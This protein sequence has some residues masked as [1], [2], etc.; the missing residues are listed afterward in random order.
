MIEI[1]EVIV[2]EGR[3]DTNAIKRAVD[4]LTIETHGFGISAET[5]RKLD[6]AYKDSGLIIFTD[7]DH[8]GKEIRRRIKEKYPEAKEAFL[9]VK[10]AGKLASNK[11][12]TNEQESNKEETARPTYIDIGIEN[13]SP[14]DIIEALSKARATILNEEGGSGNKER[15]VAG[16]ES[17]TIQDLAKAGLAGFPDSKERRDQLGDILG[18]GY[19]NG[20]S[21][22]NVLNKMRIPREEFEKAI[23]EIESSLEPNVGA[24]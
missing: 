11:Q 6:H 5:W 3:D 19:Y 4:A 17:Y 23:A 13:A 1:K 8:A 22:L 16:E 9:T 14:D 12:E 7:P 10:K 15:G 24:D 20:R 18:I 21:L 2:V